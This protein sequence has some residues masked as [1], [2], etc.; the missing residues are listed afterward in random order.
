[1][2]KPIPYP[3]D[4]RAKGWRF[5]LDYERVE[6]SDTWDLAAEVPMAQHALLMMWMV[7]W[8]QVPCGSLP[9][10]EAVIR[11]KCRIPVR[12]WN[13]MREVMMRGW[14][15]AEDGRLYHDTLAERVHE[16]LAYRRKESERRSRN[17]GKPAAVPP[18]S[19]G[20]TAGHQPESPG[21]PDT[22]TGTGTGTNTQVEPPHQ[23][24]A[25]SGGGVSA[26]PTKAG[27][28]C[29]AIKAKGVIGVNPSHPELQALIDKG[30][31]VEVFEAAAE[32]CLKA[33]PPKGMAYLLGIV[34]RQLGEATAI[35]AGAGMPQK[36]WDETRTSIE[37]KG[38]ELGL[39]RWN[40]H[41]LSANRETFAQYT[42]RVR[43]AV[44]HSQGVPA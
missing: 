37:A 17:R 1:M 30:V 22:G 2:T 32:T 20:T 8:T 34:K 13:T 27:E 6:Q 42:A 5:E 29:R 43:Q 7:A 24:L 35:A 31:P 41:D 15:L 38:D 16:M 36:P 18:V 14:W 33:T 11:A 23:N 25:Q 9:N 40:E 44:E 3:A 4:T 12:A 21:V 28:I 26:T 19:R 10:D 39:G